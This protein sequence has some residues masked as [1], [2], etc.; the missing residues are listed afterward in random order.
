[1]IVTTAGRTNEQ[2]VAKAKE[3]ATDLQVPYIKRNKKSLQSLHAENENIVVVGKD[4]IQLYH[5][6]GKEPYFFHPNV[7]M[8]RVKRIINGESDPLIEAADLKEGDSFF[9]CTLGYASD[10]IVA[11]Y[12]VGEKGKVIGTEASPVLAYLTKQGLQSWKYDSSPIEQAMRRIIVQTGNHYDYLKE[13]PDNSV[14][15]VYFDPMFE[16]SITE[17]NA[18]QTLASFTSFAPLTEEIISEAK[19]VARKKVVLKDHFRSTRF[20]QLGFQ[21][22]IRKTSK[23]HY[24]VITI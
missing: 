19:R 9:D 11:S 4:G 21:Q 1:M 13:M 8:I 18:M 6:D 17:S 20:Q 16:H 12:I 24:G 10:S 22:Q 15:V 23:F 5:R 7:A 3:V 2:Y 14:D